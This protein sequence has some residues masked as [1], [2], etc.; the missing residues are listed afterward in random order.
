MGSR[1]YDGGGALYQTFRGAGRPSFLALGRVRRTP[2]WTAKA[3]L[4]FGVWR[5]ARVR[6][7]SVA[8]GKAIQNI[9]FV[10]DVRDLGFRA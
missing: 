3:D 7:D 4:G 10:S 6:G 9:V 2:P 5:E 8:R 1:G